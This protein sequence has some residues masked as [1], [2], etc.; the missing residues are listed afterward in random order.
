M[1]K[2]QNN[3]TVILIALSV[4][5]GAAVIFLGLRK[6]AVSVELGAMSTQWIAEQRSNEHTYS[7]R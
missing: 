4:C 5:V 1:V 7:G 2:P 6:R 3:M